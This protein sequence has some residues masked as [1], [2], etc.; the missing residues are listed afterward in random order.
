MNLL[1]V[2]QFGET[3]INNILS[4]MCSDTVKTFT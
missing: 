2:F 1:C 4:N 3:D